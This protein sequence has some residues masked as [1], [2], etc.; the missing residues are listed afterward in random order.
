MEK[1]T[2]ASVNEPAGRVGVVPP[3]TSYK[4]KLSSQIEKTFT[5]LIIAHKTHEKETDLLYKRYNNV[6]I[7]QMI[8]SGITAGGFLSILLDFYP[9]ISAVIGALLATILLTLNSYSKE[10]NLAEKIEEHRKAASALLAV[11]EDYRSLIIDIERM[12][13][14]E[15]IL[16][17]DELQQRLI[18]L[19]NEVPRTSHKAYTEA[20]KAMNRK[21]NYE[22]EETK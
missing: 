2:M 9:I 7:F 19:Y 4:E 8:L 10:F 11:R 12:Q 13:T 20:K 17:R 5:S 3:V 1:I 22:A 14:E 6:R 15:I 18:Q 16:K 21:K